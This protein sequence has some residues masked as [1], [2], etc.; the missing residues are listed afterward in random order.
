MA[1]DGHCCGYRKLLMPERRMKNRRRE[2]FN[3]GI[4]TICKVDMEERELTVDYEGREVL[5][6]VSELD[7]LV[8]AYGT[9]CPEPELDAFVYIC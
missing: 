2:V 9:L 7:E 6:D 3:G 1:D 8:L 5:Y 4:G